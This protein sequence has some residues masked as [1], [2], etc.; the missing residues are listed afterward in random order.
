MESLGAVAFLSSGL[1]TERRVEG[2]F[3]P[4]DFFFK[5]GRG[6]GLKRKKGK[7]KMT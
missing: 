4:N 6:G 3:S 5:Y 7:E 1:D 2:M